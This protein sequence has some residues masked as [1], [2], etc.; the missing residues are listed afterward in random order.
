MF[1]GPCC[2]VRMSE[3]DWWGEAEL[4]RVF[5]HISGRVKGILMMMILIYDILPFF[6]HEIKRN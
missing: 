1:F 6:L 5:V 3:V 2:S 4:S